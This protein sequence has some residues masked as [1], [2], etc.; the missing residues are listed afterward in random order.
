[1]KYSHYLYQGGI[2]DNRPLKIDFDELCNAIEDN[3]SDNEYYLDLETGE[4][5]FVSE[6]IDGEKIDIEIRKEEG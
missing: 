5:L 6:Y 4:I 3:C 2:T 1:M